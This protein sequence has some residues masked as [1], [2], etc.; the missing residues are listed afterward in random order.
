MSRREANPYEHLI[1]GP[2]AYSVPHR[3]GHFSVTEAADAAYDLVPLTPNVVKGGIDRKTLAPNAIEVILVSPDEDQFWSAPTI[4]RSAV[5]SDGIHV[6]EPYIT[7]CKGMQLTCSF[8]K[9]RQEML[10][11][12]IERQASFHGVSTEELSTSYGTK[13]GATVPEY[14]AHIAGAK[15]VNS[16]RPVLLAGLAE[17]HMKRSILPRL[18]SWSAIKA[19]CDTILIAEDV[20]NDLSPEY[21][22][23]QFGPLLAAS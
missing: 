12:E 16:L 3:W 1:E 23:Q 19:S 22:E 13:D 5:E 10:A 8:E 14:L 15:F 2:M 6:S 21:F 9:T 18:L 4:E 20:Y 7:V 11:A 17:G